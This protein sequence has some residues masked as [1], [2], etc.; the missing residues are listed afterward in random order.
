[1]SRSYR[2]DRSDSTADGRLAA[3]RGEAHDVGMKS[4]LELAC[5]AAAAM[6]VVAQPAP[7]E[8]GSAEVNAAFQSVQQAVE[9]RDLK[10]LDRLVHPGFEMLHGLGQVDTR[11]TWFELVASGRLPRQQAGRR[12]YDV[13]VQIVGDT[14]VRGSIVRFR[15]ERQRRDL[16]LRGTAT[17]ARQNGRWL[18]VRQQSTA[19]HDAPLT[20]ARRLAEYGGAYAIPGRDGFSI[21]ANADYL[22]LRWANGAVLPLVPIGPDRFGAGPTSTMTFERSADGRVAGVTRAGPEGRWWTATRSEVAHR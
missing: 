3:A 15:D 22:L 11:A 4:L 14:A 17:F 1:M 20:D 21:T 7:A 13:T 16:W 6:L 12:E 19:L 2:R 8:T 10:A 9:A 5:P 18:L